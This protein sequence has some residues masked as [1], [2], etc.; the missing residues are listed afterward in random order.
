MDFGPNGDLYVLEYGI[1]VFKGSPESQLVKIEYNSGN[2]APIVQASA[3]K[4]AGA[5]PLQ[6][7][8]SADGSKD[9][10][11]DPITYEWK[12]TSQSK[13]IQA[14]KQANPTV[15]F[16]K[17][18][19][20]KVALHV[21][22]SHGAKNTK[23]MEIVAGNEPPV[24]KF[25]FKGANKSFYSPGKTINYSLMVS[26]KEDG[27]LSNNQINPSQISL[28]IDYP[29]GFNL[30]EIQQMRWDS[31]V[32]MKSVLANQLIN[33]SDCQSCHSVLLKSMGPSYSEI[34]KRY[35]GDVSAQNRLAKKIIAGGNGSWGD[36]MMP[37]HP[38][39]SE[40]DANTIVKYIL[41]IGEQIKAKSLPLTGAY[42]TDAPEGEKDKGFFVFR[43]AYTDKGTKLASAQTSEDKIIL[44]NSLVPISRVDQYKGVE[45]N[46][47]IFLDKSDV[48]A[49]A[50]GSFLG[51]NQ[52]DLTGIK[53]V[54]FAASSISSTSNH[55]GWN[56]EIRIDS[57]T[58]KLIGQTS[59]I[60]SESYYLN[61]KGER[62]NAVLGPINEVHDVYFVL[63][64]KDSTD[65]KEQIKV[66][67]IKF[68]W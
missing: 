33:K 42:K 48:T 13:E 3:N 24:V 58:G 53:Q 19:I 62:V 20:Y 8:L 49:T 59:T 1:N 7:R 21:R 54:E 18:G 55:S 60:L 51:L 28:S 41:T 39:L 2:R 10:D 40:T 30:S 14:F 5:V 52:I 67:D 65:K 35:Q 63:T 37:A 23:Y 15:T 44:R 46:R 26:D 4:T 9:D 57:P 56:I 25:D 66:K 68:I 12:I 32:P 27:S 64:N 45:F 47:Q 29:E 11:L 6:V 43:A 36:F 22:D 17:P 31:N 34:A 61:R 16:T 38:A 50:S